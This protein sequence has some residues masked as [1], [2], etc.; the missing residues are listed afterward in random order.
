MNAS[1]IDIGSTSGVC[2]SISAR[3]SRPTA[4]Y[5]SKFGRMTTASG[6]AFSAWNMGM[7]EWTP[8]MRA[9]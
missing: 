9:T 8:R 3:T 6:Q 2:S 4:V 7:A 5:F 1:S